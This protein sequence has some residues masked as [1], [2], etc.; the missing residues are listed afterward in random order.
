MMN[1]M[2]VARR[3]FSIAI[4]A[5]VLT[6]LPPVATLDAGPAI[7]PTPR[8]SL[9]STKPIVPTAR[10]TAA[11][12]AVRRSPHTRS[13]AWTTG[14]SAST[15]RTEVAAAVLA[16][17]IHVVGGFPGSPSGAGATRANEAYDPVADSWETRAEL[18][19]DRNHA[20]AASAN[21]K[22][23]VIGGF[24][25]TFSGANAAATTFEYDPD[26]DQ[27]TSRAT[28]PTPR[29]APACVALNDRIHVI[30]GNNTVDLGVHEVYDPAANSWSTS[31]SMPTPRN[32]IAGAVL[33]GRI[34]VVGGRAAGQGGLMRTHEMF[35]PATNQWSSRALLPTGR[36]GIG[37]AELAGWMH[38]IGG[39]TKPGPIS[40]F[41]A[42]EAY[43]PTSDSWVI[44]APLPTPR[45]GLGVVAH[46]GA[47]HVLLGGP[48]AGAF[49]SAIVETYRQ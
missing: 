27:W 21:G 13:G 26:S 34:H 6:A 18:P 3:I 35:D 1:S 44:L 40:T 49:H 12:G 33:Q 38:V 2:L 23:Y 11:V 29:G 20:C 45:H 48:Q 24:D 47:I 42:H 22:L 10:S 17:R 36:S 43:D 39:E 30:G 16:N 41:D 32:H 25:N 9:A 37:A 8:G 4:L 46:D 28:M 5:A 31:P 15:M 7:E 19:A 14:A